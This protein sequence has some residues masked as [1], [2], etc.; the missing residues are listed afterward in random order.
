MRERFKVWG[1]VLATSLAV[2]IGVAFATTPPTEARPAGMVYDLSVSGV[3]NILTS[4][5]VPEGVANRRTT[6]AYRVTVCLT[7]TNSVFNLVTEKASGT[8]YVCD[9]NNGTA[10]VAGSS[11]AGGNLYT[12]TF[13]AH[14]DHTYNFQ[15]ETTT[16]IV[17][18][19]VEEVRD[20]A[21]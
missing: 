6:T 17:Y 1:V 4:S 12:F 5:L 3:A 10:L 15:L 21:L 11:N 16:T 2:L 9:F 13:G 14:T 7:G 18:L 8:T 20:G 19:L